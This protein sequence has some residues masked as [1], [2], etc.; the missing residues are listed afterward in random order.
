MEMI[1]KHAKDNAYRPGRQYQLFLTSMLD[2]RINSNLDLT[3][4]AKKLAMVILHI[5]KLY[6]NRKPT[7]FL[8]RSDFIFNRKYI[9]DIEDFIISKKIG[10]QEMK[11]SLP[12]FDAK[13]NLHK[14]IFDVVTPLL[15]LVQKNAVT[16]S[17]TEVSTDAS[18]DID[19]RKRMALVLYPRVSFLNHSCKPNCILAFGDQGKV[20]VKV[21]ETVE[22]GNRLNITYIMLEKIRVTKFI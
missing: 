15:H 21:T 1:F 12:V 9:P 20:Q 2:N 19:E 13:N 22:A 6:K 7:D 5:I 3:Q 11:D 16:V 18:I 14:Q 17:R 10:L 8:Q 4:N